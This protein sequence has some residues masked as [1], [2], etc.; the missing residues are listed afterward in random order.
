M[1]SM[2]DKLSCTAALYCG[3]NTTIQYF[4]EIYN[5]YTAFGL[6]Q[7]KLLGLTLS[8]LFCEQK[9]GH[10]NEGIHSSRPSPTITLFQDKT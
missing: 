6:H 2:T 5:A 9:Y 7:V 1:E 8:P 4:I 10:C 3:T